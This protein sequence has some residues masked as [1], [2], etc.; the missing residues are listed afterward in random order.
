MIVRGKQ[1]GGLPGSTSLLLA[2]FF[3]VILGA[4]AAIIVYGIGWLIAY[5]L[6]KLDKHIDKEELNKIGN[7]LANLFN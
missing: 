3:T 2:M 6:W 5:G 7:S 4:P 1:I